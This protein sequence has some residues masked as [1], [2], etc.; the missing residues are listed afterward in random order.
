MS[1]VKVAPGKV[2]LQREELKNERDGMF[3]PRS[4]GEMSFV[5]TVL[6][7]GYIPFYK[8]LWNGWKIRVGDRVRIPSMK[9][10]IYGTNII[11]VNYDDIEVIE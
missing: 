7:V 10:S 8:H 2:K 3:V 1:A 9:G 6:E 5:A 11:V 4:Q